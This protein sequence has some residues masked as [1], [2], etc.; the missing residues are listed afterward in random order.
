MAEWFD[1]GDWNLGGY[2]GGDSFSLGG[3][4]GG[5]GFDWG[6]LGAFDW[7]DFGGG[8]DLGLPADW[9]SFDLG[10]WEAPSFDIGQW[11]APGAGEWVPS[12]WEMTPATYNVMPE[13]WG[14]TPT[15]APAAIEWGTEPFTGGYTSP[16][17]EWGTAPEAGY[18]MEPLVGPTGPYPIEE[19]PPGPGERPPGP[20][21][22]ARPEAPGKSTLEKILGY[23]PAAGMLMGGAE[24]LANY[25]QKRDYNKMLE[26]YYKRQA[27]RQEAYDK[28]M[29]D[30]LARRKEWEAGLAEMFG[31]AAGGMSEY[32]A[33][34]QEQIAAFQDD[35]RDAMD[36]AKE[37]M[38]KAMG[39]AT[40][41]IAQTQEM[42]GP[43]IAALARGETPASL[44]PVLADTKARGYAAAMQPLLNAGMDPDAARAAVLPQIEA[45]SRTMLLD[46][47]TKMAGQGI[48]VGK[49]G[50][51]YLG[52]AA[53]AAG[54]TGQLAGAGAQTAAA[55]FDPIA[56]EFQ[57][58]GQMLSGLY[59]QGIPS[60][61]AAPPTAPTA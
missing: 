9:A 47:A 61:S 11:G 8:F 6:N 50:A 54:T 17:I 22:P 38:A 4:T 44:A 37:V 3:E 52:T 12:G 2:T 10:Q 21:E 25:F 7:G 43:A 18:G 26:D 39:A 35:I 57:M 46:F 55:A 41:L 5:G 60:V 36:R 15:G 30:Y 59:S 23:G 33:A 48:D 51:T 53:Q 31:E 49:L 29:M 27:G 34:M 58:L 24:K 13:V 32:M 20:G 56:K 19:R 42:L 1:L 16:E 45:A 28:E 40:P 14:A